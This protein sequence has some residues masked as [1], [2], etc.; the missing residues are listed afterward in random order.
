MKNLILLLLFIPLISFSQDFRKMSFGQSVEELKETY[1]A[2]EFTFEEENG[3]A[4]FS[5]EDFVGG[6]K[7]VVAYL[8]LDNSLKSGFYVYDEEN[9]SKSSDDRYKDYKNI[10]RFLN[11]KY[12]MKDDSTWHNDS[13]KND[14]NSYSHAFAM[15]YV[16][17]L[18]TYRT[19]KVLIRH[20]LQ[21]SDS[22]ITHVLGYSNPE[23]AKQMYAES[24]SDF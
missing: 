19:E 13:Y 24:E 10:S 17:F 14:S 18:E 12:K 2:T 6:I 3:V 15:G 20:V 22:S 23:F 7:T 8:F 4:I 1:P 9:Y 21:K 16:D 5:H 11:D